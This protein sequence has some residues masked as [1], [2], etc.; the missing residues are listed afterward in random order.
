M[1]TNMILCCQRSLPTEHT[2]NSCLFVGSTSPRF[3]TQQQ[4]L[5]SSRIILSIT[6]SG[7]TSLFISHNFFVFLDKHRFVESCT[8]GCFS[9]ML[10]FA[11]SWKEC[12][13]LKSKICKKNSLTLRYKLQ[14]LH[15][16]NLIFSFWLLSINRSSCC[17][18]IL[19]TL[20]GI[21]SKER[22]D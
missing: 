22:G 18:R 10:L 19:S 21:P 11:H 7:L 14:L 16:R 6:K 17:L 4:H 13:I 20:Y 2:C 12:K 9:V 3:S 8:D 1:T 5:R 15:G